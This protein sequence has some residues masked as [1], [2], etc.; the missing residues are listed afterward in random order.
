MTSRSFRLETRSRA[1]DEIKR[2]VQTV[3]KVRKWE[4][5][6][7][8]VGLSNALKVYK[9]V[10]M[11][12]EAKDGDAEEEENKENE[13]M[14]IT[15]QLRATNQNCKDMDRVLPDILLASGTTVESSFVR[16]QA[17]PQMLLVSEEASAATRDVSI[18]Q[19]LATGLVS[20]LQN[21]VE[22]GLLDAQLV[23]ENLALLNDV[24]TVLATESSVEDQ[25]QV[26]QQSQSTTGPVSV[27]ASSDEQ[28]SPQSPQY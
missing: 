13:I 27:P 28:D 6:W 26:Y 23:D 16:D 21:S 22:N 12:E 25:L 11:R 2:I 4:K 10:P 24:R 19:E 3:E 15:N 7:V 8:D 1:K 14:E 18:E 20:E 5:K 9:W 17:P